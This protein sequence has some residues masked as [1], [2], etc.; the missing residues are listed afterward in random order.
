ML[1]GKTIRRDVVSFPAWESILMTNKKYERTIFINYAKD[2]MVFDRRER[3]WP[4]SSQKVGRSKPG[5][6]GPTP[7]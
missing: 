4:G 5:G 7:F 2:D 6:A 3:L 1:L